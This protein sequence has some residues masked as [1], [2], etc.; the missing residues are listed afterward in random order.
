MQA[1][2]AKEDQPNEISGR[3][4]HKVMVREHEG[5]IYRRCGTQLTKRDAERMVRLIEEQ[6]M[7]PADA[8]GV[9]LGLW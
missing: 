7:V 9:V 8:L 6:G 2:A 4:R 3:L 5:N 1:Y